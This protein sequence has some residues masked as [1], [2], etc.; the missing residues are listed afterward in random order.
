MQEYWPLIK[1]FLKLHIIAEILLMLALN[2]NQ[3]INQSILIFFSHFE[4]SNSSYL[5]LLYTLVYSKL[6]TTFNIS[7]HTNVLHLSLH[8]YI[9]A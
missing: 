9:A 6:I 2:I 4:D 7:Q 8:Y 5:T 1:N 3:S